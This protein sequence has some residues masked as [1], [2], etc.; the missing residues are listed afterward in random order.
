[1]DNDKNIIHQTKA[2]QK[3][4]AKLKLSNKNPVTY[5]ITKE[6]NKQ[7]NEKNDDFNHDI[8]QCLSQYLK[9]G[10]KHETSN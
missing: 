9:N 4:Y 2:S 10:K 3:N 8:L 7:Q 1:L 5:A 6:M